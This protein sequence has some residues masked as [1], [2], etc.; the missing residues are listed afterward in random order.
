VGGC[1][2]C[3][4]VLRASAAAFLSA[5]ALSSAA[6]LFAAARL[7]AAC[8]RRGPVS[9]ALRRARAPHAGR[10]A[11][12]D[13][14]REEAQAGPPWRPQPPASPEPVKGT[15]RVQLVRRDGRDASTLYGREGGGGRL[16]VQRSLTALLLGPLFGR[17]PKSPALTP[18]MAALR[19]AARIT[20]QHVTGLR[21][22]AEHRGRSANEARRRP[23]PV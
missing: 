10:A 2:T 9:C 23:R 14:T 8:P 4:R 7:S 1:R 22:T 11:A 6:R 21:A 17:L 5:A 3:S 18:C 19:L 12:R 15:R 16:F 20:P 13:E